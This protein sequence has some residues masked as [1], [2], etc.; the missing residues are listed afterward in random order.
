MSPQLSEPLLRQIPEK[1]LKAIILIKSCPPNPTL[2][3]ISCIHSVT[4]KR[5]LSY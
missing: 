1:Y 2:L 4:F 3:L 5:A